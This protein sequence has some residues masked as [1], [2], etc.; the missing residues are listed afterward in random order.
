M[1]LV[2]S[3]DTPPKQSGNRLISTKSETG[4]HGFGLKS[5][6]KAI[7]KYDGDYEWNYDADQ[8]VFTITVMVSS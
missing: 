3:C 1:I 7:E 5:V 2:N 6:A 4:F 8:Q